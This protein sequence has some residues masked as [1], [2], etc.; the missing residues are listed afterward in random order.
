[1]ESS[2][3]LAT[4]T[5][6]AALE[7]D[8]Q[9]GAVVPPLHLSSTYSF[10]CFSQ[11]R[12]YD[13]TRSGNPTRDALGDAL[14][15]LEGGKGAVVT[16]SGMAAINLILQLLGPGDTVIAPHDCYGGTFRLLNSLAEK[17]YFNVRFVDQNCQED[18]LAA[19]SHGPKLLLA[20]TPSNPLLRI[21]DI[22]QLSAQCRAHDVLLAVDNTFLSPAL[23]RPISL[24][25]DIVI[26]STTKYLNGHSDVV[27]GAVVAATVELAEKLSWWANCLGVTGAP[28]DSYLTL[29]G[30]RTLFARM[31]EHERNAAQVAR[32]LDGHALV[33]RVYYPGLK[34]H[35]G[36]QTACRQQSGFGGMLSFRVRGGGDAVKVFVESLQLFSLA[37]S[38]GGIESLVCHPATMTHAAVTESA[39]DKAGIGQDLIRLSIGLESADDL[40]LDLLRGLDKID[41]TT[42]EADRSIAVAL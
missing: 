26:H 41:T 12:A 27:G 13:Y 31:R 3:S 29:R 35:Q 16:S 38:L 37:E 10:Q 4:N 32:A 22:R 8:T 30:M 5:V 1:M 17:G 2:N 18:L 20:E 23:Q 33:S 42:G 11:K 40:I 21:V 19:F 6:R 7:S 34:T 25:A 28:F 39:L 36:Y 9:F 14:N 15:A 24:G